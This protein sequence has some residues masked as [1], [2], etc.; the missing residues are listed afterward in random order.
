MHSRARRFAGGLLIALA[1]SRP[2]RAQQRSVVEVG[3]SLV[4]FVDDSA[5]VAGPSLRWAEERHRGPLFG[6]ASVNGVAAAGAATGSAWVDG[7]WRQALGHGWIGEAGGE[8][9]SVLGT[10]SRASSTGLTSL[11][12]L[13]TADA[14]GAWARVTGHVAR[15]EAGTLWGRGAEAGAWRRWPRAQLVGTL[16]REW[17]MAQLFR[18]RFYQGLLGTVPVRYTEGSLALRLERDAATLDVQAGARHD[19]DAARSLEPS[20]EIMAA[21][22]QSPTRAWTV[23]FA[24]QLPDFVRGG[25]ATQAVSVGLRFRQA[26][27]AAARAERVRPVM[28]LSVRDDGSTI[29]IVRAPGARRVEIMADFTDWLPVELTRA[30]DAFERAITVSRGSH[31]VVVRLDGGAWRPAANTPAVDDDFGGRVGLVVSP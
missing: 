23:S 11:R 13:W 15:R 3:V 1:M 8:A 9:I 16:A 19:P 6:A 26:T 14:A 17:S 30:D 7:G 12:L 29:V 20:L 24:R 28:R 25:D 31:R 4:R 27:P 22:W 2:L 5:T 10:S 21:F 18:D